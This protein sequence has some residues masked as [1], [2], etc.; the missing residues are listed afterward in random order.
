[1]AAIIIWG[2]LTLIMVFMLGGL[3]PKNIQTDN[4]TDLDLIIMVFC[5]VFAAFL[6]L[7][8]NANHRYYEHK[9]YPATEYNINKTIITTEEKGAI[10]TDTLYYFVKK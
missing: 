1:M 8:L 4:K 9:K 10:K 7:Y 3:V 6:A 2:I 5:F